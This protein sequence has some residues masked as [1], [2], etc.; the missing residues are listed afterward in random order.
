MSHISMQPDQMRSKA[1][2]L[3]ALRQRHLDLMRQ[4]RI[5][6]NNLSDIWQGEAQRAFVSSF[7]NKSREMNDLASTL[8][9][10]IE[11]VNSAAAQIEQTDGQL[12][13]KV[14]KI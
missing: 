13:A 6:V 3:E 1:S 10:Y 5:L 7:H 14:N 4:L 2:E 8:E 9:N 11:L 12:L